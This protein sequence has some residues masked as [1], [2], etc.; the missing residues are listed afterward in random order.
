MTKALFSLALALSLSGCWSGSRYYAAAEA[1]RAI[2]AGTYRIVAE[3]EASGFKTLDIMRSRLT[4]A[5]A[6]DGHVIAND[7]ES[8]DASSFILAKLKGSDGVYVAQ[9]DLDGDMPKVGS[10]IFGLVKPTANGYFLSIPR[11]DQKR[12]ARWSRAVVSGVLVGKPVC[13]FTNRT[14]LESALLSY[15]QDPITWT[16]YRRV[17]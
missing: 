4:I 1:E 3:R 13:R 9:G 15:A 17:K 16:E 14:D 11:C 7:S 12:L 2:P 8:G 5:Y 6:A 10:A